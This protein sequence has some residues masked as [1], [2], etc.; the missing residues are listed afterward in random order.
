MKDFS[1]ELKVKCKCTSETEVIYNSFPVNAVVVCEFCG[2]KINVSLC[3]Q[4]SRSEIRR[5]RF[6]NIIKGRW[7][8][9]RNKKE[10]TNN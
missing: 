7:D 8:N 10:S 3:K 9:D 4:I 6:K 5:R 1:V 2:E